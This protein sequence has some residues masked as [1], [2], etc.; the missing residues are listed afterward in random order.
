MIKFGAFMNC[1]PSSQPYCVTVW[2]NTSV[3]A[4]L[5]LT[6]TQFIE[7]VIV[8]GCDFTVPYDRDDYCLTE[9]LVGGDNNNNALFHIEN[10]V[11]KGYQTFMEVL[12]I[13]KTLPKTITVTSQANPELDMVIRFSRSFY[14]LDFNTMET[15]EIERINREKLLEETDLEETDLLDDSDTVY[16]DSDDEEYDSHEI[17]LTERMESECAL[18]MQSLGV[19]VPENVHVCAEY[20]LQYMLHNIDMSYTPDQEEYIPYI[21]RDHIEVLRQMLVELRDGA[22]RPAEDVDPPLTWSEVVARNAPLLSTKAQQ[23]SPE[24]SWGD[25]YAGRV[26]QDLVAFLFKKM[27]KLNIAQVGAPHT[28]LLHDIIYT[29]TTNTLSYI[30]I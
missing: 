8:I 27:Y 20:V 15:I 2:R 5:G 7:F 30:H 24:P 25:I 22:V 1:R 3:A 21:E 16:T 14:N 28:L 4:C 29:L 18:Y 13:F 6:P 11:A 10:T 26:Y 12:K 19:A 23:H 9:P 17:R